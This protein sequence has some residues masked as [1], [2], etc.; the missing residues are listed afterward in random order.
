MLKIAFFR[1]YWCICHIL[2]LLFSW[3]WKFEF[4]GAFLLGFQT[5]KLSNLKTFSISNQIL[6]PKIQIFKLRKI[7]SSYVWENDKCISSTFWKKY[8]FSKLSFEEPNSLSLR[9]DTVYGIGLYIFRLTIK[10]N[11]SSKIMWKGKLMNVNSER[12]STYC[13]ARVPSNNSMQFL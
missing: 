6:V 13:C 7:K 10:M 8:T 5:S 2:S 1:K 3:T 11:I 12:I 9:R 4:L